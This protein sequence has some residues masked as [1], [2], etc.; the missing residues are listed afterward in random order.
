MNSFCSDGRCNYGTYHFHVC[1]TK[2]KSLA[3][4]KFTC[5]LT[6][7]I[8]ITEKKIATFLCF[9]GHSSVLSQLCH[10]KPLRKWNLKNRVC[11]VG[12]R[13][14]TVVK[15]LRYKLEGR[16]FDPRWCN[17]I[18]HWHRLFWSHYGPGVNTACNRN[19]YQDYFLVV[20]AARA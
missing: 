18:F 19:E 1:Q 7:Y 6:P 9:Y 16:W 17:G 13:G 2:T 10:L 20:N 3:E 14:S 5:L 4:I 12:D 8:Q 15:V 11:F